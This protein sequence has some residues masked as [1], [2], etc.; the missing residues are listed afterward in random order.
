ME[1][2]VFYLIIADAILF[3]HVLFVMFVIMGMLLIFSGKLFSWSWVRNPWFR[4]MHLIAICIVV[5]QSWLGVI[6]PLTI[7]E[8]DLR[9]KAGGITYKGSF[10]S[11]WLDKTLYYHAPDWVFIVIYT[12]FGLLVVISWFWIRPRQFPIFRKR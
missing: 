6:C 12:I 7:W 1:S 5:I 2:K 4:F 8:M 9:S 10:L 3:T 11:H